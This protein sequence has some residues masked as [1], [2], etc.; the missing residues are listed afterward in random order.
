[1]ARHGLGQRT[2]SRRVAHDRFAGEVS[3]RSFV[4]GAE[5]SQFDW[6]AETAAKIEADE[7]KAS[8]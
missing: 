2:R 1:M 3:A 4:A 5:A 6:I 7:R 8:S